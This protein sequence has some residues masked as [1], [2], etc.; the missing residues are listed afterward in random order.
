MIVIVIGRALLE[1]CS[2]IARA[3]GQRCR[4]SGPRRLGGYIFPRPQLVLHR[5][6]YVSIRHGKT[7]AE[8]L[9][10]LSIPRA[11]FGLLRQVESHRPAAHPFAIS[12]LSGAN[13]RRSGAL[14]NAPYLLNSRRRKAAS[15]GARSCGTAFQLLGFNFVLLKIRAT[16]SAPLVHAV[17]IE[18][19]LRH[20]RARPSAARG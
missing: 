11:S 3:Y 8:E 5:S 15:K 17:G 6:F 16:R 12:A 9:Y 10:C 18:R 14:A 20:R 13:I 1:H 2:G 19:A 4:P 7:I